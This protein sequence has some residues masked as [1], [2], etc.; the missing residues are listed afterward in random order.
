MIGII[1]TAILFLLIMPACREFL[2]GSLSKSADWFVAWAPFSYI[3][4]FIMLMA[5]LV[6]AYV[7]KSGPK[8]QEPEDPLAR[9]KHSDDVLPD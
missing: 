5:P 2:F 1:A 9:Y 6:C 3:I 7:V 8:L 4:V